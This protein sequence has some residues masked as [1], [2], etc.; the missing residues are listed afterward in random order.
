MEGN[1]PRREAGSDRQGVREG[2]VRGSGSPASWSRGCR[3]PWRRDHSVLDV[4]VSADVQGRVSRDQLAAR[5]RE[6]LKSRE[7]MWL[8]KQLA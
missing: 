3:T 7:S 8:G 2:G 5:A 6:G 1:S 4:V